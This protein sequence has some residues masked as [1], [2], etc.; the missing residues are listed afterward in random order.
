MKRK[1]LTL[2]LVG[3]IFTGGYSCNNPSI[4]IYAST[5]PS[6]SATESEPII[7]RAPK[8]EWRF[9]MI[10]GVKHKRLWSI[11]RNKWISDWIRVR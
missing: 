5:S 10:N 1:I 6:V 8:T 9:K 2:L 4:T 7:A 11:T 3:I